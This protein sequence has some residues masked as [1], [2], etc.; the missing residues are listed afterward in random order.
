MNI[1]KKRVVTGLILALALIYIIF[2]APVVMLQAA[3]LALSW[4]CLYEFYALF[5]PGIKKAG[6]K[7]LGL[8][9]AVPLVLHDHLSWSVLGVL[10]AVF[11]ILNLVFLLAFS[12]RG[13]YDWTQAQIVCL[14]LLYVPLV[15][16]LLPGLQTAELLLVF[17]AA[18]GTDTGAYY[19]GSKL[20]RR[21]LWPAVSPKKS[22]VGA[23]G[24]LLSCML[25]VLL[26]GLLFGQSL[27]YHWLWLGALL[28]IAAQCG[29][30]FESGLKRQLEVKDSGGLLPGHGGFL[31]RFDSLLLVL[32]V[33]VGLNYFF[34]F[35]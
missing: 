12:R 8:L 29:D 4:L 20:G 5:W 13:Q 28:S 19:T 32:P 7:A 35:F 6:Y 34:G 22:W 23:W 16:Q 27:W 31:D 1:E 18:L 33:Y 17:L 9:A 30:L 24:G 2:L 11:W 14:G 10:L 3:A 25:L 26:V 15:W 21:R